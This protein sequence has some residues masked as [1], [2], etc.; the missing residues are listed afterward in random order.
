MGGSPNRPVCHL[1]Q[2]TMPSVLLQSGHRTGILGGH[3]R[4][5]VEGPSTLCVPSHVTHSQGSRE[6][7]KRESTHN[8]D[9]L[10]LGPTAMVSSASAHVMPPATPPTG[11]AG[12]SHTG[13]GVH[14]AP[15]SS[16]TPPTGVAN[17][18]L[19]TLESTCSEGVK[20]VLESSRRTST[21]RTYAQ[22]RKRFISWCSSKQLVPQGVPITAILEYLLELKQ[23][24]LSLSSLKVHLAAISAFQHKEEGP[25]IFAHP[26]VTRF[27][28]GQ[29]NLYP[30]RKPLSPSWSLDLVLHTLSGPPFEP[31]ATVPLRLLTLKTTFL[32]AITSARKVSELAAIMAMPPCTVF[33]KEVVILRLHPAFLPKVSSEFHVN[34]PIVLPSFYP[35][36]HSSSKEA[37]LHLL[38]IRRALAFYI[39]R[40]KPFWKTDRLLVSLAPRSKGEG[41]SS[42][43]ISNHIVSCIRLCYELK[44]TPLLV[45]PRAHSTRAMATSTAF[46]KGIALKDICRAATWSSYDTFAKHY[47]MHRVFDEDTCLSTAV[48]SRAS[49]T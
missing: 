3:L 12:P 2:Q 26:M 9:N 35:K 17:P 45:P 41:L 34:E 49:C 23:D 22:K 20:R 44:K 6:S 15:T 43:R 1:Q 39:D 24:G 33:S 28:K 14:S 40:T 5:A 29:V 19:S 48:L 25:T 37:R 27:L 10:N 13:S 4:G 7:Q 42:Q 30:P 16:K 46:F 47:A 18:W 21:R 11:S 36:P 38:D 31:L 8:T 32:L